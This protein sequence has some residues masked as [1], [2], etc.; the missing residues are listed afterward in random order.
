MTE[1]RRTHSTFSQQQ[2]VIGPTDT[3]LVYRAGQQPPVLVDGSSLP[4]GYIQQQ[5][6]TVAPVV[7]GGGVR[8]GDVYVGAPSPIAPQTYIQSFSQQ[9]FLSQLHQLSPAAAGSSGTPG[10]TV[11]QQQQQQQPVVTPSGG[12]VAVGRDVRVTG[13]STGGQTGV[14]GAVSQ[15]QV[16]GGTEQRISTQLQQQQQTS[17]VQ[18]SQQM[19]QVQ[20]DAVSS[21]GQKSM[22]QEASSSTNAYSD[23]EDI[24]ASMSELDTQMKTQR[25]AV[26]VVYAQPMKVKTGVNTSTSP[27]SAATEISASS[28]IA[29]ASNA[30]ST[31]LSVDGMTVSYGDQPSPSVHRHAVPQPVQLGS[32]V[33]SHTVVG[34]DGRMTLRGGRAGAAMHGQ[35][36]GV[37]FDENGLPLVPK[38]DCGNCGQTIVGPVLMALGKIWHVQHFVCAYCKNQLGTNVFYEREGL[39]YCEADYQA[40]FLPKCAHCHCTIVEKCVIAFGQSWHPEHFRCAACDAAFGDDKFYEK[41]GRA[42]C[43][44]DYFRM[45]APKCDGCGNAIMSSYIT[46]VHQNWHPEC[47]VCNEC[48]LPFDNSG[49]Y[50][51][52]G[53]MY[54]ERH[55]HA[56]RGSLCAACNQPIIGGR[57]ITA[58]YRKYHP[59]HFTCTF[60]LQ[61]LNKGT[62]KEHSEKPYCHA[63]FNKLFG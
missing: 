54:C 6:S 35:L 21:T 13:G 30:S 60:C 56:H 19:N 47:F 42:Y 52:N 28:G 48:R 22:R 10:N 23:L 61:P 37:E 51:L 16:A 57:C 27:V 8:D 43:S 44:E 39:P 58:L 3:S 20:T 62:F 46:A 12:Q 7:A 40:L 55:F 33:S 2:P 31:G 49:F 53:A 1:E 15:P 50:E 34:T 9:Q 11:Q 36:G 41:D 24:M 32:T 29:G 26:D 17:A 63:C 59:D 4:R 45:Y 5:Q 38:G 25:P 18:G 14:V